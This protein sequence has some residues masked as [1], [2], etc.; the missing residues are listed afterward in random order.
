MVDPEYQGEG[1]DI[2]AICKKNSDI[3]FVFQS[4]TYLQWGSNFLFQGKLKF[5]GLGVGGGGL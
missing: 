3:V 1:G 4:S 2:Q 5:S